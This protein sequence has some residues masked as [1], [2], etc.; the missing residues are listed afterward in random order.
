MS[1]G[2][3][4]GVRPDERRLLLQTRPLPGRETIRGYLLR[5]A[6]TNVVG[7]ISKLC[8][9]SRFAM[10]LG[11]KGADLRRIG[12]VTGA[13]ED[14]LE[15]VRQSRVPGRRRRVRFGTAGPV[16]IGELD[17]RGASICPE[18]VMRDGVVERAWELRLFLVCPEHKR[19]L[20]NCCPTCGQTLDWGRPEAALC[21]CGADLAQARG[22]PVQDGVL[23][24]LHARLLSL[25]RG[26]SG[27]DQ[28]TL[29]SLM[30]ATELLAFLIAHE[31]ET[32]GDV[33]SWRRTQLT[34]DLPADV[35]TDVS[36]VAP[37][38]LEWPVR[39][40]CWLA[41]RRQEDPA[42]M[43]VR[44]EFGQT[45]SRIMQVLPRADF[46]FLHEEVLSYLAEN[47]PS[48]RPYRRPADFKQE[49]P[50]RPLFLDR[51]GAAKLLGVSHKAIATLV[52]NGTLPGRRRR[53]GSRATELIERSEVEAL[54]L[55]AANS[56]DA[57]AA[58]SFL[59]TTANLVLRLRRAGIL[60][61]VRLPI[62]NRILFRFEDVCLREFV[63][64]LEARETDAPIPADTPL[65]SLAELAASRMYK[66][67]PL[68]RQLL[69]GE[70]PS[71]SRMS[72]GQAPPFL[73]LGVTKASSFWLRANFIRRQVAGET[74]QLLGVREIAKLLS[75]RTEVVGALVGAALFA[76]PI[77]N[78]RLEARSITYSAVRAFLKEYRLTGHLAQH[79]RVRM[80]PMTRHLVERG[81]TPIPLGIS[82]QPF[83]AVWRVQE[84]RSA[85]VHVHPVG[86]AS[87]TR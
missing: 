1:G 71:L 16:R 57:A 41:A 17:A 77:Q 36:I 80:E 10:Q 83:Q 23:L 51:Q 79:R 68:M 3:R 15:A 33:Q 47:W 24:D 22:K 62:G 37:I 46:G 56:L 32:P 66:A 86:K 64:R 87:A 2:L 69:G 52:Q 44:T 50:A 43:T 59:G 5:A 28:P 12:A 6:E 20:V 74:G 13:T 75:T 8:P 72:D 70:S 11:C 34:K 29:G 67:V 65:I 53:K 49:F 76:A 38:M 7:G 18:C 42:R 9:G 21:R 30:V 60:P 61:A 55:R 81:L 39:F 14:E 85:G 19:F 35:A 82:K 25:S 40:R 78:G 84:L 73:R 58:G 45:F 26:K 4:R 63:S 27:G 54:A 31:R 48:A